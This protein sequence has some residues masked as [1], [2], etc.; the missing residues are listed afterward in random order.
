MQGRKKKNAVHQMIEYSSPMQ[1]Q[2]SWSNAK[3]ITLKPAPMQTAMVEEI[4]SESMA[5][6]T[7]FS[8]LCEK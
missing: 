4:I 7:S 3:K 2:I 8:L 6:A 1:L 5:F